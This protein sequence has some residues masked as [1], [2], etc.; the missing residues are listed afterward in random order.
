MQNVHRATLNIISLFKSHVYLSNA[1]PQFCEHA[2]DSPCFYPNFLTFSP[3]AIFS[4]VH[5]RG[6]QYVMFLAYCNSVLENITFNA[7]SLVKLACRQA[8]VCHK[9][10][11]GQMREVMCTQNCTFY[12][13]YIEFLLQKTFIARQGT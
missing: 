8:L 2:F 3:F 12:T 11:K 1:C 10:Q 9:L 4:S 13:D 7:T 6:K 5:T